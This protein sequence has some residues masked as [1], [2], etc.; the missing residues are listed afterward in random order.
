MF[1]GPEAKTAEIQS[2]LEQILASEPFRNAGQRSR[3]LRFLVE[4]GLSGAGNLKEHTIGVNVYGRASDYDPRIDPL[5]RVQVGR[6]R[7]ALEKY[8]EGPGRDEPL[9]IEIPKGTYL[10]LFQTI[11]PPVAVEAVAPTLPPAPRVRDK[12]V[13]LFLAAGLIAAICATVSIWAL[14]R[15]GRSALTSVAVLP[16]QNLTGDITQ[17]YVADGVTELLTTELAQIPGL[18]VVARTSSY[19]FKGKGVDVREVGRQLGVAAVVEG[20]LLPSPGGVRVSVQLNRASDG[21]HV[22][23]ENFQAPAEAMPGKIAA[24]MGPRLSPGWSLPVRPRSVNREA[25]NNY[26][27]GRYFW[28]K[29]TTS[30]VRKSIE[31]FQQAINIDAEYALAYAGLADSYIVLA[32]NDQADPGSAFMQARAAAERAIRLD[33]QLGPVHAALAEIDFYHDWNWPAA[34]RNFRRAIELTPAYAT[35]HHWYALCLTWRGQYADADKE[36]RKALDLDPLS[37]VI[38]GTDGV[39]RYFAGDFNGALQSAR[40][41]LDLDPNNYFPHYLTGLAWEAQKRYEAARVEFE[42][43]L[44]LAP[45]ESENTMRLAHFLAT[46]GE[47]ARA[48]AMLQTM[49]HPSEGMRFN[50][51]QIAVVEAGLDD[52]EQAIAWLEKAWRERDPDLVMLRVDPYLRAVREDQRVKRLIVPE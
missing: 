22:W 41:S 19:K 11:E 52:R 17:D 3:L 26:L 27:R 34:Q 24:G 6:L 39:V 47:R 36:I 37:S 25:Y 35:A 14:F 20:S 42:D 15:S 45:H 33:P 16:F 13:R 32:T 12:R 50:P 9:R 49:L 29:R 48:G 2:H 28:N 1:S 46:T 44:R 5:V 43:A 51:Y 4:S 38:A 23:A 10:P 30:D 21:Y 7:T 18:R 31:Y 8:Y 40:K